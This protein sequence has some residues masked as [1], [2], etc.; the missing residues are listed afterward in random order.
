MLRSRQ[1]ICAIRSRASRFSNQQQNFELVFCIKFTLLFVDFLQSI[2]SIYRMN[3][4]LF[5]Y[6][7]IIERVKFIFYDVMNFVDDTEY[8][9]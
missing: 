2:R 8:K 6:R 5:Q 3:E 4:T 1:F 9:I 7:S